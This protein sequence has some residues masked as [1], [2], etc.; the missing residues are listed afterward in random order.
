MHTAEEI[1]QLVHSGPGTLMG[2]LLRR[3][4]TPA[5]LTSEIA[6]PD[7]VPLRVRLL[8][9]DLVAFRDT[10]G[11]V[12]LV[13]QYCPH[14]GASLFFGR[15]EE[16]GLRCVYHG[17]KFDVDG[18]CLDMPAERRSFADRIHLDSYPVHE[19]GGIIWTYMG[20]PETMTPFRDFGTES[21]PEESVHVMKQT[22][23]NNWLQAFDGDL[24]APHTSYLH[25]YFAMADIP[26][27][28]SDV[29]DNYPS[30]AWGFKMWWID[31]A[32]I[33]ELEDEWHGFRY[34]A[35]RTTPNGNTHVRS[36]SYVMPNIS[37]L[38][39]V[40]LNTNQIVVVPRDD[41]SC[42]RY[43]FRTQVIENPNG[44]GGEYSGF[45]NSPFTLTAPPNGGVLDRLYVDDNDYGIDREAQRV[46]SYTG[47]ADAGSQDRMMTE[48]MGP[49]Y[50][51]TKEHWGTTD[52]AIIR[53]HA[54][55]LDAAL[56][57]QE[58]GT[59]PPATS[60]DLD[61]RSIRGAEKV[62]GVG[63]DWR[64]LGTEAD[65]AVQAERSASR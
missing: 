26:E 51:R 65:Q 31:R 14:R 40:P 7:C 47:V 38:A 54:L 24:D 5:C 48:S 9:E 46:L 13:T 34:A 36:Y 37:I 3:Y 49:I 6:E 63:E 16:S 33:L 10:N 21:L 60:G 2:N 42:Y 43:D 4:W 29:P 56:A 64:T 45:P 50:D 58:H 11:R 32:P 25:T 20:P 12:G 59:P 39:G 1:E 41:H 52:L 8:G 23:R 61:Y 18:N 55:L 44:Y 19:S 22:I 57:L 30:R 35:L 28:G 62:L 53:M 27:D 17:W 15:N